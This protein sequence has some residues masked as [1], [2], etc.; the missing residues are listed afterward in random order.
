MSSSSSQVTPTT[1]GQH[2]RV[3]SIRCMRHPQGTCV[4]E[5]RSE[6][7]LWAMGPLLRARASVGVLPRRRTGG[8]PEGRRLRH[9]DAVRA[10][11]SLRLALRLAVCVC[12]DTDAEKLIKKKS[13]VLERWRV[14]EL[15]LP[16]EVFRLRKSLSK[17][18][19]YT[20]QNPIL[21]MSASKNKRATGEA[22]LKDEASRG[23]LRRLR[24]LG[25][26]LRSLSRSLTLTR[27]AST[28]RPAMDDTFPAEHTT[29]Y[30]VIPT[31][32]EELEMVVETPA[33]EGPDGSG[34]AE[35][36]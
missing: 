33:V 31:L 11:S 1:P 16:H 21:G 14:L 27:A 13:K 12:A 6:R 8:M 9:A 7:K 28:R 20:V 22:S 3:R 19:R 4:Q 35:A 36:L 34:S 17:E 32:V 25:K 5:D 29:I 30:S 24:T 18:E 2:L 10:W 15:A 23:S 26:G